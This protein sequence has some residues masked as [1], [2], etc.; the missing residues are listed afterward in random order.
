VKGFAINTKALKKGDRVVVR[1]KYA[2]DL[3]SRPGGPI[4][5]VIDYLPGKIVEVRTQNGRQEFR[6]ALERPHPTGQEWFWLGLVYPEGSQ[7]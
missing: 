4:E 6:V 2:R 7:P 1:H 3:E 5:E